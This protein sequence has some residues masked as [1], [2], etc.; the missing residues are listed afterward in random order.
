[1]RSGNALPV[2]DQEMSTYIPVIHCLKRVVATVMGRRVACEMRVCS[3]STTIALEFVRVCNYS[4]L[5]VVPL[6]AKEM[7]SW[8]RASAFAAMALHQ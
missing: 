3:L 6:G 8:R 4:L 1:M 2:L 5:L 7:I